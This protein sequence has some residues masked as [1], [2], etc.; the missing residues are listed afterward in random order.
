[1]IEYSFIANSLR[2]SDLF[3]FLTQFPRFRSGEKLLRTGIARFFGI[4]ADRVFPFASG[5]MG[6][7]AFLSI[8]NLK[9]DDE[10]I[11]PGYTCVVVTNAIK[12]T[13]ARAVYVDIAPGTLNMATANIRQAI[14]ARTKAIIV[15]HNFGI[16]FPGIQQIRHDFPGICIVEDAA[17]AL[18]SEVDGRKV[19]LLGD[20]S[21]FSMEYSKPITTGM[22]GFVM[23]HNQTYLGAFQSYYQTLRYYPRIY[24]T[25]IFLSLSAHLI[26]THPWLRPYKG[27]LFRILRKFD[28]LFQTSQAETQG[29]LPPFYPAKLSPGLALLGAIQMD[30]LEPVLAHKKNLARAY[31]EMFQ[32][33]AGLQ[34]FYDPHAV[35]VRYPLLLQRDC[36]RD[37]LAKRIKQETGLNVGVWFNDVVHPAGSFRYCYQPSC[38]PVGETVSRRMINLPI[39]IHLPVEHVCQIKEKLLHVMED[40]IRT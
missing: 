32:N 11:V 22:G 27:Y 34:Q 18:G 25:R 31:Y 36:D 14:S 15:S 2:V 5:R 16:P 26:T 23:I 9:P 6:L 19:G 33:C 21:F 30:R 12:Y 35:Y 20:V 40:Y 17:H 28:L 4:D 10:V 29:E 24:R 8:L 39:S 1:M 3:R 13:G 7:F 37:Q 38:C